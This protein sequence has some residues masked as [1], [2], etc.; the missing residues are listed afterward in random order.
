VAPGI[1]GAIGSWLGAKH[2]APQV[3][4][5]VLAVVLVIAGMKLIVVRSGRTALTGTNRTRSTGHR[6]NWS[7]LTKFPKQGG[8]ALATRVKY[9]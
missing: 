5:R 1:G 9:Q 3:L 8:N 6:G 4:P 2:L 7:A